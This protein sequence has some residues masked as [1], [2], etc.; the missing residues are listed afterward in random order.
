MPDA[1]HQYSARI[2]VIALSLTFKSRNIAA[3]SYGL[4]DHMI[5]NFGN[6]KVNKTSLEDRSVTVISLL[7][8]VNA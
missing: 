8:S 3:V 6:A 5:L 1:S 2:Q 4:E 7:M